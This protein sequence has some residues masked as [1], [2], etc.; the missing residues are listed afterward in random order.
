MPH[1]PRT[2]GLGRPHARAR[3]VVWG[4]AFGAASAVSL[5]CG[6]CGGWY[7]D[8]GYQGR[9]SA[10]WAAQLTDGETLSAR[11]DA[12][13]ALGHVLEMQPNERDAVAALVDV[14]ADTSDALRV[15][16]ATALTGAGQGS[17]RTRAALPGA[18]PRLAGL[19]GDTAHPDVR[20]TAARVLGALGGVTVAGGGTSALGRALR[21]SS[22]QVRG[23]AVEAFGALGAASRVAW[24]ALD[25]V[26]VGV[27]SRDPSP[28]NRRGAL[29]ALGRT[30]APIALQI[31]ALTR[32]VDDADA[33]VRLAAVRALGLLGATMDA[34]ARA[35]LTR[36]LADQNAT[37]R[38]E[39][40]HALTALHLRGGEDPRPPE[41]SRIERCAASG[42]RIPEC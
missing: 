37:V 28:A 3:A 16:A 29:T 32:A 23:A 30:K 17:R 7:A 31:R 8:P 36:A 35:A 27:A 20:A 9:P 12:A 10:S 15:A 2:P 19:L 4:A 39:A 24:P 40:G 33:D 38:Q 5:A 26:L 41:P 14:L 1:L 34:E 21:D 18:V 11:V 22:R 42:Y 6:A 13:V 25:T